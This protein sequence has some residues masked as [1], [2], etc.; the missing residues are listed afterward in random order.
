MIYYATSRLLNDVVPTAKIM[1][2]RM[3][4]GSKGTKKGKVVPVLSTTP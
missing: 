3:I 1:Q 2:F 4:N